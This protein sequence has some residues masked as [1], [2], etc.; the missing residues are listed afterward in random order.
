MHVRSSLTVGAFAAVLFAAAWPL[1]GYAFTNV[2]LGQKVES[3][4]MP[5]LGGGT[6]ELVARKALAN[7][8]IFFR[9]EQEH[10]AETL[11]AMAQCEKDFAGKPVHWVAIVS[12]SYPADQVT[13]FVRATG[14]RMPVLVD[15]GDRLYGAL[16]VRLHPTIGIADGDAT[17]LAYEPFRKVQYC[18]IVRAR[19]R[20]ALHE[21]DAAEVEK[22]VR[23]DRALMPNDVNGAV[24]NR[25]VKMGRMF[26]KA[27]SWAKAE[28]AAREALA[29]EPTFAPA[30]VLL[31]DALA[32][33]G[34]CAA[35]AKAYDAALKL[36]P[37]AP[38][39]TDGKKACQSA[40]PAPTKGSP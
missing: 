11:R 27:K 22:V 31:G 37:A 14:I 6:H 1:A 21:I 35:A 19:I 12:G 13:A 2:E 29:K 24:A 3:P 9:P 36:D 25:H 8:F 16:G 38:G 4:S 18:D 33:Q 10:S 28:E 23:P 26:A 5:T 34:D 39:A 30:H 7:V 32:A 20:H 40:A 15:E 17:L